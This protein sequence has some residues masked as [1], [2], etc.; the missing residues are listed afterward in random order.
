[1]K[2]SLNNSLVLL[3]LSLSI[4]VKSQVVFG[5]NN[6]FIDA[7]IADP[8][9]LSFIKARD[10]VTRMSLNRSIN[11]IQMINYARE[12]KASTK[13]ETGYVKCLNE[14]GPEYAKVHLLREEKKR[15]YEIF[16]K[17]FPDYVNLDPSEKQRIYEMTPYYNEVL[18][19]IK[20]Y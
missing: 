15:H 9:Y 11:P 1:M 7:V 3:L 6:G 2:I 13:D 14:K 12:C 18:S 10:Q 19:D 16:V 17:K 20:S 5:Q 4:S 8:D